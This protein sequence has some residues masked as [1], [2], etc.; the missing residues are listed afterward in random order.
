M[1]RPWPSA[2]AKVIK[3]IYF[4]S[5]P[6]MS[7]M[8]TPLNNVRTIL[9]TGLT[10]F[11]GGHLLDRLLLAQYN[12]VAIHRRTEIK[13]LSIHPNLLWVTLD[14]AMI[15]IAKQKYDA[16]IHL[17]TSYHAGGDL[18]KL[19]D[20]NLIMPL[21]LLELAIKHEIQLF[22]NTDS[23][24]A[25]K[26]LNYSHMRPYIKS[27]NDFMCWAKLAV[28]CET[29]ST[30][31]IVNMRLEHVYGPND[32]MQKFVPQTLSSLIAGR[33]LVLTKGEQ[34]RDFVHVYD[35][36][37]AYL[38]ILGS[39]MA[40]A[41]RITEIQVGTGKVN[42]IRSFVEMAKSISGS[43]STIEFGGLPYREGEIMCSS[44]DI[45]VLSR[46]GWRPSY[47]IEMG[48]KNTLASL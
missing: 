34:L 16:I 31:R 12:V 29:V 23:F 2:L 38:E 21:K 46:L 33:D 8:A 45:Q 22:I 11:I 20:S 3:T 15:G 30:L 42:S 43:I 6:K 36:V 32:S 26:G 27:K 10:G 14:E 25:K 24:W 44:A 5:E 19:I 1:R 35:V 39:R 37:E 18:C 47:S 4:R 13:T 17:A 40:F 41:Q 48:I 7:I 28:E 9:A